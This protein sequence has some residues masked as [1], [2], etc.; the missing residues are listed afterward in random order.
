MIHLHLMPLIEQLLLLTNES[1]VAMNFKKQQNGAA[2]IVVLSL[3]TISLMLG[4]SS[5]QSSLVDERLAG[6]HKLVAEV[7]MGAEQAAA[8]GYSRITEPGS[9]P[10]LMQYLLRGGCSIESLFLPGDREGL[11]WS[12]VD[13]KI[14]GWN[15]LLT[16][17]KPCE[18]Y[19]GSWIADRNNAVDGDDYPEPVFTDA[20]GLGLY[21]NLGG[22]VCA[23]SVQCIYRYM[24][25]N[26]HRYI[27]GLA[28]YFNDDN[29]L[30]AESQPVFVDLDIDDPPPSIDW[31]FSAAPISL[32]AYISDLSVNGANNMTLDGG[33]HPDIMAHGGNKE[34]Y[35][36]SGHDGNA[37]DLESGFEVDT[38]NKQFDPNVCTLPGT[39]DT[40]D[41]TCAVSDDSDFATPD[42]FVA[43]LQTLF[44][45]SKS[46]SKINFVTEDPDM[47]NYSDGI[48]IVGDSF[49]WNG[50]NDFRGTI[51][52]LGPTIDYNGGGSGDLYGS[53][54]HAPLKHKDPNY[55]LVDD[56]E[57]VDFSKVEEFKV[58][59]WRYLEETDTVAT[60]FDFNGG[61]GST[62][63][64]DAEAQMEAA[65]ELWGAVASAE[66]LTW[67]SD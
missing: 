11:S 7:Q 67:K 56:N 18:D 53:M 55:E 49:T 4:L 51:I 22:N 64:N 19:D 8:Q 66:Y 2:L 41:G 9:V 15:S 16:D 52:V 34:L 21:D 27:V 37:A 28:A 60:N 24:S 54:I 40:A 39:D 6:N 3:L 32:L 14:P 17:G 65:D 61:G 31:I 58:G 62:L 20:D 46:S 5:M 50:N 42:S 23:G 10:G 38:G 26:G 30:L 43:V 12:N 25:F 45:A 35:G 1:E 13:T 44:E 29:E 59:E 47:S 48:L 33:D 36:D 63:A 57:Y